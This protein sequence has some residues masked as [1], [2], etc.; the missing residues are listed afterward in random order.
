LVSFLELC[1]EEEASASMEFEHVRLDS[2]GDIFFLWFW[3]P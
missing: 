3:V 1:N 2:Q